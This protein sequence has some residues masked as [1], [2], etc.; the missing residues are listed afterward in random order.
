VH[1][2]YRQQ[3]EKGVTIAWHRMNYMLGCSARWNVETPE[4][5]AIFAR[6]QGSVDGR[7]WCIGDQV[8]H[9]SAWMESAIQSAH[10]ALADLDARVRAEATSA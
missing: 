8:S 2:D 7:Y 9:H 5:Q 4:E 3:V 10:V 6:L 1:P